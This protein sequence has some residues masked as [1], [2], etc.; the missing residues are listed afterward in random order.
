MREW[1]LNLLWWLQ[2]DNLNP[3]IK[4][5]HDVVH[6]HMNYHQITIHMGCQSLLTEDQRLL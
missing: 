5:F 6:P 1:T 4:P 2:L 3:R